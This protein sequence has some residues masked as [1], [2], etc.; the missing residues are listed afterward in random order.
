MALR[1]FQKRDQNTDDANYVPLSDG[2]IPIADT[3]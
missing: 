1:F 2:Y 3:F